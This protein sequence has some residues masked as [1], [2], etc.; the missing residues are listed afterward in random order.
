VRKRSSMHI[1][2]FRPVLSLHPIKPN[3]YPTLV[4]IPFP[5]TRNKHLSMPNAARQPTGVE[6]ASA[7]K[8]LLGVPR[9]GK[10][11]KNSGIAQCG[12]GY[13][14]S[15]VYRTPFRCQLP[16]IHP[17]MC[18]LCSRSESKAREIQGERLYAVY[19]VRC[20]IIPRFIGS[21]I[22]LLS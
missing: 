13:L 7:V 1:Y 15:F 17:K 11:R 9:V 3:Q 4:S 14:T 20:A 12:L 18:L 22:Q 2:S 16:E 21:N 8:M 19:G 5:P 6:Y 10:A